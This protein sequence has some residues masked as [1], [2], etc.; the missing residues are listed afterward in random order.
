MAKGRCYNPTDKRYRLH[1]GRGIQMCEAWRNNFEQFLADIG[2][3][4][5]HTSLDRRDNNGHYEPG[6]ARWATAKEQGRNQQRTQ[7]FVYDGLALTLGEWTE[8][9]GLPESLL[10]YRIRTSH[11]SVAEALTTPSQAKHHNPK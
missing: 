9:T 4:P 8:R 6:N 5:A 3:R 1:G 11:W 10:Y 2:P 7:R